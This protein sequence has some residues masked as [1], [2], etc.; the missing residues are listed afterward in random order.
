[1]PVGRHRDRGTT[2]QAIQAAA[3]ARP[4][5]AMLGCSSRVS[6]PGGN[7]ASQHCKGAANANSAVGHARR[8]RA[9]HRCHWPRNWQNCFHQPSYSATLKHLDSALDSGARTGAAGGRYPG[10][11][12]R[13]AVP[14]M[15]APK[16]VYGPQAPVARA[17][18]PVCAMAWPKTAAVRPARRTSLYLPRDRRPARRK[19][20][21]FPRD[22]QGPSQ[23]PSTFSQGPPG[24]VVLWVS[25]F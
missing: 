6:L 15:L 9:A 18:E 22:R 8:V 25:K 14:T 12:L 10:P 17:Q 19:C 23:G 4:S 13:P 16:A 24:T 1:M 2:W 20:V 7:F 5:L 11:G 21:S 3:P